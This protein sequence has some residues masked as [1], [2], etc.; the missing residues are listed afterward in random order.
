M[1]TADLKGRTGTGTGKSVD[2]LIGSVRAINANIEK[3][4]SQ[5]AR[6]SHVL[7]ATLAMVETKGTI[8]TIEVRDG[9]MATTLEGA[10]CGIRG[11]DDNLQGWSVE[12]GDQELLT[13]RITDREKTFTEGVMRELVSDTESS[14]NFGKWKGTVVAEKF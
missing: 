10:T 7:R 2:G 3:T 9:C 5:L 12:G 6:N 11:D 14:T 8:E 4:I 1:D 13:I